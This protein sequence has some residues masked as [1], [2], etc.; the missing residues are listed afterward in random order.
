MEVDTKSHF[1]EGYQKGGKVYVTKA[2][3]INFDKDSKFM[4][5]TNRNEFNVLIQ[6]NMEMEPKDFSEISNGVIKN[7]DFALPAE[8]LSTIFEEFKVNDKNRRKMFKWEWG[9]FERE[10]RYDAEMLKLTGVELLVMLVT[11]IAQMYVLK[12]LFD[13]NQII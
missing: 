3:P 11:A 5:F 13:K 10:E 9:F 1:E 8:K 6:I 4:R 12:S 2:F 7:S